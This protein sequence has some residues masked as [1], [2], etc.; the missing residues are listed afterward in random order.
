MIWIL[1]LVHVYVHD[2]TYKGNITNVCITMLEGNGS[3]VSSN[4]NL[5]KG[6]GVN[7]LSMEDNELVI[8]YADSENQKLITQ[9]QSSYGE[10]RKWLKL[11]NESAAT[12][13]CRTTTNESNKW[14]NKW[15]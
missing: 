1:K 12:Q 11:M 10:I 4:H 8:S 13:K 6:L 3:I 2:Y 14:N 9:W 5:V 7:S 15:N